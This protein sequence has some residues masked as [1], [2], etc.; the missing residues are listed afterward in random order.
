VTTQPRRGGSTLYARCLFAL[1]YVALLSG[2]IT[3]ARLDSRL[4]SIEL[5]VPLTYLSVILYLIWAGSRTRP[6]K[7]DVGNRYLRRLFY[8]LVYMS[9]TSAWAPHGATVGRYIVDFALMFLLVSIAVTIMSRVPAVTNDLLWYLV[10]S[11]LVYLSASLVGGAGAQG[12]YAALGGGPNVYVRVVSLG[13]IS[14]VILAV[15]TGRMRYLLIVPPLLA[16]ALLSGSRGGLLALG[17]VG[18]ISI[19]PYLRTVGGAAIF[20]AGVIAVGAA[21]VAYQLFGKV[22]V[23]E[24]QTRYRLFRTVTFLAEE[25]P[26]RNRGHSSS[27]IRPGGRA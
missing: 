1:T 27:H 6:P 17:A 7:S 23:S 10:G 22:V 21:G 14:A 26:S 2:Q 13:A 15:K 11:G 9:V 20:R 8:L 4:P 3:A 19:L 16:G 18:I 24:V 25:A 12:R 5:R